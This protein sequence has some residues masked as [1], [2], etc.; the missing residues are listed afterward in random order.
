MREAPTLVRAS[1]LLR[2]LGSAD[3]PRR[4][5]SPDRIATPA[6]KGYGE[7]LRILGPYSFTALSHSI[8]RF[9][10]SLMG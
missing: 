8:L 7:A 2:P 10:S 1:L 5:L 6:A 3:P 9:D 4:D